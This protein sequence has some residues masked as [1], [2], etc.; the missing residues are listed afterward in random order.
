MAE[1]AP[2]NYQPSFLA[3]TMLLAVVNVVA[4]ANPNTITQIEGEENNDQI[5]AANAH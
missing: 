5:V 1:N 3:I 4:A 2:L